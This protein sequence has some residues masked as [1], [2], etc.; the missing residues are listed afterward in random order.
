MCQGPVTG[1]VEGVASIDF[2]AVLT[3]YLPEYFMET[4]PWHETP[5]LIR[6]MNLFYLQGKRREN[7]DLLVHCP[8][9]PNGQG[10][11]TQ[12]RSLIWPTDARLHALS[13]TPALQGLCGQQWKLELGA[14]ARRQTQAAVV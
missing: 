12:S 13:P 1:F 9:N 10:L 4:W 3:I 5:S 6:L 11:R 7:C 2:R 8:N 14:G